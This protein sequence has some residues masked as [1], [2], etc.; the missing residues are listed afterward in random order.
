MTTIHT[1][2]DPSGKVHQRISR[3]RVYSHVVL[4]R[5][6]Y[7]EAMRAAQRYADH[8]SLA[9]NFQQYMD[10]LE[11]RLTYSHETPEEAKASANANLRGAR[12]LEE[13]RAALIAF[14]VARVEK[15]KAE[16]YYD[17]W[18]FL[19]WTSRPDLAANLA[20]I[21]RGK[22]T[23]AEVVIVEAVTVTK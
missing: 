7:E 15:E 13:Y 21:A 8:K 5:R 1:A 10:R 17:R 2:L 22:P 4:A 16:G 3:N 12:T 19:G 18:G 9:S 14:A 23:Y 6:S 20:R 11:G